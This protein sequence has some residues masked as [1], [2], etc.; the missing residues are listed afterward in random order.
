MGKINYLKE[1]GKSILHVDT[2]STPD[3]EMVEIMVKEQAK[4]LEE[5]RPFRMIVDVTDSYTTPHYMKHAYDF[6]EKTRHLMIRGAILGIT[7]AKKV[8][9][10]GYNLTQGS[11]G[12]KPCKD[13]EEAL[14]YVTSDPV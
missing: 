5:N 3:K 13:F 14:A 1:N 2:R 12:L 6:G 11:K 10:R 4:I 9:L 7:G 8:L